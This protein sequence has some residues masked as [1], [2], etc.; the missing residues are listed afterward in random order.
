MA[1]TK[2]FIQGLSSPKEKTKCKFSKNLKDMFNRINP[3][4]FPCLYKEA[5]EETALQQLLMNDYGLP[6][7]DGSSTPSTTRT[8]TPD[9]LSWY[10]GNI[11]LKILKR[12]DG[13]NRLL[14]QTIIQQ[15]QCFW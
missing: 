12:K 10:P 1:S 3:F 5:M 4:H 2:T 8:P 11:T 15:N 7:Q 6:F 14:F 9:L 13:Q